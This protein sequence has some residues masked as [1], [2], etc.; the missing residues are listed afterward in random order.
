[1]GA[2]LFQK[3]YLVLHGNAVRIGDGCV[4]CV[5]HSGAGKSTLAA[6]F[7]QRG[8]DLL[9]DDVVP[10]GADCLAVPG[11]P[12]IKLWKDAATKLNIDT[13]GLNRIRPA[14]EKFN[15][16]V[17]STRPVSPLPISH[18]YVLREEGYDEIEAEPVRGLRKFPL[19][20][21]HTYRQKFLDSLALRPDHLKL[22][23]KL[24][25]Q[26]PITRLSRPRNR[27]DVNSLIDRI[28]SDVSE[29][30]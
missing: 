12:R 21:E 11:F 26:T 29:D 19:L 9:A 17:A 7:L 6:G 23:G 30:A 3:G 8:F 20:N 16:P 15:L 22:C 18:I 5:G 10:V 1:L 25:N 14:M 13:D 4:I 28:L 27:F 2:A 24:A